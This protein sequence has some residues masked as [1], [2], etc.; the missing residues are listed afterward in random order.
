MIRSVLS[1]TT[2]LRAI[3]CAMSLILAAT[4][5]AEEL[6]LG[7]T[8]QYVYNS[9]FFAAANNEDEA[10]SFQIGPNIAILDGEGRFRYDITYSGAYQ[11]YVDQD[12]V[13]DWESRLRVRATYDI[14]RRTSVQVSNRFRDVTN[15]RFGRQDIAI[16]NGALDPT[17]DQFFRN[18]LE[19]ELV[20]N[21]TRR[22]DLRVRAGYHWIDF[23]KNIDRSDSEAYEVG[24]ELDY[25]LA[26]KHS[27]GVG[28]SYIYQEFD[29][30]LQSFG[31]QGDYVT[32]FARWTWDVTDRI[33][34]S[35]SGGPAWVRS[36]EDASASVTQTQF[37]G[38]RINDQTTRANFLSCNLDPVFN[39]PVASRCDFNT[40]PPIE[41]ADLGPRENFPILAGERVGS[42]DTV[43]FFGGASILAGFAEWNLLTTY[44]RRQATTSG[45][46]LASS[47]DQVIINLEYAPPR[48]RWSTFVAFSFDRRESLTESTD[49]DYVVVNGT[50]GAAERSFAFTRV[51]NSERRIDNYVGIVGAGWALSR[52]WTGTLEFRYR[53]TE[54]RNGGINNP[55]SDTYL[56]LF[57]IDYDYD[58]IR[59][60]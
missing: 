39:V 35:M 7:A 30:D 11:Y 56:L 44:A 57:T 9:N 49:I 47:F 38:G 20:R 14:D 31:S 36:E 53:K 15:L 26:T 60:F 3:L 29:E 23:D 12:G 2:S 41:A 22:W 28:A 46:S 21:L 40:A 42:A 43:T 45:D 59:L 50:G 13:D 52:N 19:V 55:D 24:T 58:P 37:V 33:Q 51:Q 18:D 4:A 16:G 1:P 27:V 54:T 6:Q 34:F 48:Y 10:N 32:T 17:Q 5:D 25:Q 8:G